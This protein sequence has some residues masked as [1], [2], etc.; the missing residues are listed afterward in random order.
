ML[1]LASGSSGWNRAARNDAGAGRRGDEGTPTSPRPSAESLVDDPED[2]P[3]PCELIEASA[4]AATPEPDT[5]AAGTLTITLPQI[6][7]ALGSQFRGR[8]VDASLLPDGGLELECRGLGHGV[9]LCQWGA[10]GMSLPPHNRSCEQ[11]LLHYYTGITL[12]PPPLRTARLTVQ[13][14]DETG[15]PLD[16]ATV[17][18]LP[19]G[20]TGTTDGQGRLELP[21]VAD[22]TYAVE[23]RRGTDTATFYAV[24]VSAGKTAE[25]RLALTWRERDDRVARMRSRTPSRRG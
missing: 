12:G 20:M 15:Q 13:L 8:L 7:Q 23:A 2:E 10:Q 1:R 5:P 25:T 24:R 11:I 4:A 19:G 17:R 3:L 21:G 22:G 6:R 18:L 16:D 9:G 14:R